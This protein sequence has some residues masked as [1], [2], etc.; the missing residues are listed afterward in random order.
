MK[1]NKFQKT[2]IATIIITVILIMVGGFVRVSGAGLGC[3]DWPK[4]FG[5][6]FP[7]FSASQLP[8]GFDKTQFN[9]VLMWTE[10][11]NRLAGIT[12]GLFITITFVFSFSYRKTRPSVFYSSLLAFLL[13][14]FEG[15]LGGQV[16]E[17]SLK[18]WIITVHMYA[19]LAILMLLIYATFQAFSGEITFE[20][21]QDYQKKFMMAGLF[22]L[23]A[24]LIEIALGAQLRQ[25][26]DVIKESSQSIPRS[27]WLD[28]TGPINII[29]EIFS[30]FVLVTS[31]LLLYFTT[32]MEGTNIFRKSITS[33]LGLVVFQ[34]ILGVGL[35]V[36]N[37]APVLQVMHLTNVSLLVCAEFLFL[38]FVHK[39]RSINKKAGTEL[40][41]A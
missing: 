29:H 40:D 41:P 11:I 32:T 7:P 3:P 12:T 16:V 22:L 6:W 36:A 14:G 21:D 19:A 31:L 24:T 8:P 30:W 25:S 23:A 17:S 35:E 38:L 39:S 1:L 28:K 27:L 26:V 4:C 18:G 10:Y 20:L 15:W 2:A 13:V 37:L 5:S 9:P 34:I 33:I